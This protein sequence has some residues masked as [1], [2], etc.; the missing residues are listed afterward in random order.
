MSKKLILEDAGILDMQT[1]E[2]T[3]AGELSGEIIIPDEVV[4]KAW[5]R[6]PANYQLGQFDKDTEK[7]REKSLTIPD[8]SYTV[9]EII[10]KFSRGVPMDIGSEGTFEN[11]E[12]FDE[13]ETEN[14]V[15]ITDVESQLSEVQNRIDLQKSQ[16]EGLKAAQV[17]EAEAIAKQK[18]TAEANKAA[19]AG[20]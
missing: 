4:D 16:V 17:A 6:R 3:D 19:E 18:A 10:E 2:I 1:G 13:N 20:N 12:E 9:R 5:Y 15:D 14:A 11:V 7:N 8:Q